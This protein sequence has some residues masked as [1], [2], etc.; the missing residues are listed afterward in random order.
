MSKKKHGD[1][2]MLIIDDDRTYVEE[3]SEGAKDHQIILEHALC[4]RDGID[5]YEEKG[6]SKYYSGVVLDYYC[7]R[8]KGQESVD[9]NFVMAAAKYFGPNTVIPI[10]VI[11]GTKSK[12][13]HV[14]K[15][16]ANEFNVYFKGK[17][18][19]EMLNYLGSEAK[20]QP[21]NT[22]RR[23]H[24]IAFDMIGKHFKS[25]SAEVEVALV[26]CLQ[27]MTN[28]DDNTIGGNLRYLR[29]VL[30]EMLRALSNHDESMIPG[31]YFIYEKTGKGTVDTAGI[32]WHLTGQYDKESGKHSGKEYIRRDSK[33]AKYLYLV[34]D[35]VSIGLHSDSEDKPTKENKPT[36]YDVQTLTYAMLELFSW[37][38]VVVEKSHSEAAGLLGVKAQAVDNFIKKQ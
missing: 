10:V 30:E 9:E 21:E 35:T 8:E 14:K 32:L 15:Q 25:K 23:K 16:C 31:R 13:E 17:D 38:K 4:L 5:L 20:R 33:V 29:I 28:Q 24:Q 18:E 36:K 22:I 12:Q 37:F 11:T 19:E 2:K 3:L 26:S 7:M 27:T 6:E 34:K 1:F